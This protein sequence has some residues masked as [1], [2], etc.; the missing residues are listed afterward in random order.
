MGDMLC[1]IVPPVKRRRC[2]HEVLKYVESDR[3]VV[4]IVIG[5]GMGRVS[6]VCWVR[7]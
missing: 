5:R 1:V 7:A 2:T 3:R 4:R 6:W